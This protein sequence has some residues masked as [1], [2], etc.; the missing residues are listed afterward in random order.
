MS[1]F[2]NI[3]VIPVHGIKQARVSWEVP[4]SKAAGDVYVA[5]S[6]TGVQGSWQVRNPDTPVG[7]GVGYYVDTSL[8]ITAGNVIGYYR[9]LHSQDS[10]DTFSE[11][12]GIFADL[13][14]REYGMIHRM[15]QNEFISMRAANGFPIYHCIPRDFG[16]VSDLE[17]PDTGHSSGI[18]CPDIDPDDAAYGEKYKGGF[19]DPLLTWMRII[20]IRKDTLVDRPDDLGTGETD[21]TR[22]R[23]LSFPKPLRNHLI[24]DP[25]TDRRYL[26]GNE[27]TPFL[28][29]GIYPIAY[30]VDL[31]YLST[32][33][34]RYRLLMPEIDLKAYRK[35]KYWI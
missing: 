33:D 15:I 32:S 23:F 17:D 27:V 14:R 3:R 1:I 34:Q 31:H 7:A 21:I 18:E 5:F 28:Y 9:L 4:A 19:F 13:E 10:V 8:E 2:R 24:V 20:S 30:E 11:S 26:V 6:F 35:I 16:T 22:A 12:V 29:R 25:A